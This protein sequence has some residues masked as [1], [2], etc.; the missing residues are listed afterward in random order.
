MFYDQEEIAA[1]ELSLRSPGT[2]FVIEDNHCNGKLLIEVLLRETCHHALLFRDGFLALRFSRLI[3]PLL[4]IID[5]HLPHL[6]G[7]VLYDQL[8]A[9]KEL[10]DVPAI[11][12]SASL[13]GHEDEIKK[14]RLVALSKPFDLEEFLATVER[15]VAAMAEQYAVPCY[16][17]G[18]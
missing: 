2:I 8:H 9:L 14:R 18:I 4:F 11:I 5:C 17:Q 15:V 1:G 12:L 6:D 7:L 3:K 16:Q 13:E 10:K